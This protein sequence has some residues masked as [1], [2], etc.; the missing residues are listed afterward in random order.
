MILS[1][2]IPT[3][4]RKK[5]LLNQLNSLN[6]QINDFNFIEVV[7]CDNSNE[8]F[9]LPNNLKQIKYNY[10]SE[11]IGFSGN[12]KKLLNIA[13]GEFVWFLSDDDIITNDAV[14]II[15]DKINNNLTSSLILLESS[16]NYRGVRFNDQVYFGNTPEELDGLSLLCTNWL[17]IIFL[18]IN[19][20]KRQSL[21][22]ELK[23]TA[24]I[25]KVYPHAHLIFNMLIHN[26]SSKVCIIKKAIVED[27]MGVKYYQ[28][29][30]INDVAVIELANLFNELKNTCKSQNISLDA[31][32]SPF[33]NH[34]MQNIKM[35]G[36]MSVYASTY[37]LSL[38]STYSS[39]FSYIRSLRYLKLSTKIL[40][41]FIIFLLRV[42]IIFKKFFI[43]NI[44]FFNKD[45]SYSL[46]ETNFSSLTQNHIH[47]NLTDY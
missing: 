46:I 15:L 9:N 37:N 38:S 16:A 32:M 8:I 44:G 27:C 12:I 41:T 31:F 3:Y 26:L 28:I 30:K 6:N 19:V 2:L 45:Y 40:L 35:Y 20:V 43:N 33:E 25:N 34:L 22:D 47:S 14:E 17:S 21:L 23:R 42:N 24:S 18:S 10:N 39:Q 5:E 4:N 13:R 7:V 36:L 1:V 29:N 11:N